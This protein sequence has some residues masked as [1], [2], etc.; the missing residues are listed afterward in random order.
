MNW[1]MGE[2]GTINDHGGWP[3]LINTLFCT[4]SALSDG[5]KAQHAVAGEKKRENDA[6]SII[7]GRR[8]TGHI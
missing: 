6:E 5:S 3:P 1:E 7:N 4:L 2:S 8:M